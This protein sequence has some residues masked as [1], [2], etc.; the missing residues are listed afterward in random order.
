MR[1]IA[2]RDIEIFEFLAQVDDFNAKFF[3]FIFDHYLRTF[4]CF[5]LHSTHLTVFPTKYSP[6]RIPGQ[7]HWQRGSNVCMASK[8]DAKIP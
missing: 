4:H 3:K 8:V 6:P 1:E 5:Y 7:F 2:E